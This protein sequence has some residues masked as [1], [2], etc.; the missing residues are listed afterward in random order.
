M[1]NSR[2][3]CCLKVIPK[4]LSQ[5]IYWEQLIIPPGMNKLSH[6]WVWSVKYHLQDFRLTADGFHS[7]SF[8]YPPV[9][10]LR[11]TFD[12]LDLENGFE[13]D[14]LCLFTPACHPH[15]PIGPELT[16]LLRN[17]FLWR[18]ETSSSLQRVRCQDV[19][20][21]RTEIKKEI[22]KMPFIFFNCYPLFR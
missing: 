14:C 3:T 4:T 13:Q 7:P 6:G 17:V 8:P 1:F 12:K 10:T 18:T 16:S 2:E 21:S 15:S 20:R 19:Q 5:F 9:R 22:C 11:Q